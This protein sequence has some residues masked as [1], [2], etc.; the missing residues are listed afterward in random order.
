MTDLI[1]PSANGNIRLSDHCLVVYIDE[2]GDEQMKDKVHPV[3]GMGGLAVLAKHMESELLTP[4]AELKR[5]H[6]GDP[7]FPF[8]VTDLNKQLTGE[9]IDALNDFFRLG[10]FGRLGAATTAKAHLEL[11][12]F[13]LLELIAKVFIARVEMYVARANLKVDSIVFIIEDSHRAAKTADYLAGDFLQNLEKTGIP[14][15]RFIEGKSEK[16]PGLE[17]SDTIAHTL[18]RQARKFAK[19]G[20]EGGFEKDFEAVFKTQPDRTEFMLITRASLN[21]K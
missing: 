8:H 16:E 9:K 10:N 13:E 2:T 7:E 14:V 11:G 20:V 1:I 19:N 3:F 4:W 15:Y 18:G 5:E 12:E 21:P 17:V 6:F